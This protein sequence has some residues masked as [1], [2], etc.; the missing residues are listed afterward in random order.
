VLHDLANEDARRIRSHGGTAAAATA[1][2]QPW[3]DAGVL[4]EPTAAVPTFD[5]GKAA[6][7]AAAASAKAARDAAAAKAL[8]EQKAA[9]ESVT[10]QLQNAVDKA[11]N[12]L[13]SLRDA[14]A[15]MAKAVSNSI[16][17]YA[18]ITNQ[19]PERYAKTGDNYVMVMRA[20]MQKILKFYENIKK[21][22]K[23]KLNPTTLQEIINAGP[24]A[25][26][27]IAAML[28]NNQSQVNQVNA[29]QAQ[30]NKTAD[31]I[32]LV[33][34]NI[35]YGEQIKVAKKHL[36]TA[37]SMLTLWKNTL[38]ADNG[39]VHIHVAG[40]VLSETQL[41]TLVQKYANTYYRRNG[42]SGT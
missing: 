16:R 11:K 6:R 1:A 33:S 3:V 22:Q 2:Q 27:D 30:I 18:N 19:L 9:L 23:E 31:S 24:E 10:T 39:G 12:L 17:N 36:A 20:R 25:G 29:L 15:Q 5:A 38:K 26:G 37:E 34:S 41:W 35:E 42:R 40:S 13:Q 21:L 14:A 32:G 8:A 4:P 28:A 7:D